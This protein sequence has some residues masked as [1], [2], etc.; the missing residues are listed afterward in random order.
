[1]PRYSSKRKRIFLI[2][3]ARQKGKTTL[4]REKCRYINLDAP[5]NRDALRIIPTEF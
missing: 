2:A 4:A 5:E 1:L 3:G